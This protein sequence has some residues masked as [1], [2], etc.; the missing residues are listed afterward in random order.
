MLGAGAGACF[1]L[2]VALAVPVAPGGMPSQQAVRVERAAPPAPAL[3][4]A[5]ATAPGAAAWANAAA[6]Y[7]VVDRR[8]RAVGAP[9]RA[10]LARTILDEARRAS[11]D[12]LLVVALIQ[13][14]SSFDP[15]AM[16]SAGALGLMQ[17]RAPTMKAEVA[18][19]GLR[20]DDPLDPSA[21]VAAG[22][23]YL[24]RLFDAFDHDA[25]LALMA[26]NAGP[27][28]ILR[29]LRAG[30][31]P[32]R[33]F[34]Y[35]R[36]VSR[37]LARLRGGAARAAA[38][39]PALLAAPVARRV[40]LPLAT[41]LQRRGATAPAALRALLPREGPA[42]DRRSG[43][44]SPTAVAV[45]WGTERRVRG[46]RPPPRRDAGPIRRRRPPRA[47][48]T[49]RRIARGVAPPAPSP[50]PLPRRPLPARESAPRWPSPR[51]SSAAAASA[52]TRAPARAG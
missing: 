1:A 14:E 8:L 51:G 17:L 45:A 38:A 13:V 11:L 7:A 5:S 44:P 43:A 27:N 22:V 16:S 23:R 25:E 21:N 49:A 24:R 20:S 19:W 30:G 18:R 39:S 9:A 37:E 42:S 40:R 28:R 29:H 36:K 46:G 26:Y 6:V 34:A 3:T 15:A 41:A 35:P 10:R 31:V 52:R 12:P 50:T 48:P 4:R 32:E 33:F 47:P 2:A